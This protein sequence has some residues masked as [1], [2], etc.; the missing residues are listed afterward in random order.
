[1]TWMFPNDGL[2]KVA[3]AS[4]M[5][6]DPSPSADNQPFAGLSATDSSVLA[7]VNSP[8][9]SEFI[10][11]HSL[12]IARSLKLPV[13]LARVME[14]QHN[15]ELPADPIEWQMRLGEC[16]EGLNQ[17]ASLK[18]P[19][20]AQLQSVILAGPAAAELSRWAKDHHVA[21]MVL[22]T[23]ELPLASEKDIGA[24]ALGV[25]RQTGASV[26]LVPPGHGLPENIS[27]H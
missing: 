11:M 1:M 4:D 23:T 17:L 7:C 15:G 16:R 20:F 12:A 6:T 2:G 25:L 21:L 26:L 10:L 9:S 13:T 27:Y 19:A 8:S 5:T 24:T 18:G 14:A 22:A 3:E